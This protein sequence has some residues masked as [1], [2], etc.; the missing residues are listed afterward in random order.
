[1]EFKEGRVIKNSDN[2]IKVKLKEGEIQEFEHNGWKDDYSILK[3]GV[4]VHIIDDS[5][6]MSV[7]TCEKMQAN[8]EKMIEKYYDNNN[9]EKTNEDAMSCT[10]VG[11]K[12]GNL[13]LF[14]LILAF[15]ILYFAF[16]FYPLYFVVFILSVFSFRLFKKKSAIQI[17][18]NIDT[19]HVEVTSEGKEIEIVKINPHKKQ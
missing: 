2:L 12:E 16:Q 8:K 1:M 3:E 10:L 19:N 18:C 6:L 11:K 14:F 7:S 15:I 4:A 13:G 5:T 9:Y 17:Q